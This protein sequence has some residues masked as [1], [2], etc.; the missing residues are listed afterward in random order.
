M[1]R[2]CLSRAQR[3]AEG[4][5]QVGSQRPKACVTMPLR[6]AHV[7][8]SRSQLSACHSR[9]LTR[10]ARDAHAITVSAALLLLLRE[11]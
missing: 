1:A 3:D 11:R 2:D 8:P 9:R 6:P 5:V 7:K 10:R 4:E